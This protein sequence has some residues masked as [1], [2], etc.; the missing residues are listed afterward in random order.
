MRA[1]DS[2]LAADKHK[3]R[4]RE[5]TGIVTPISF[6][7]LTPRVIY[8]KMQMCRSMM[9]IASKLSMQF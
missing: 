2:V 4:R 7:G 5:R 6:D 3:K 9:L 1:P 8:S